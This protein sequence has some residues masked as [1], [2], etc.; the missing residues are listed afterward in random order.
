VAHEI[1]DDHFDD[2]H[3]VLRN[4]L[5]LTDAR[6]VETFIADVSHSRLIELS[7]SP[8]AGRFDVAHLRAIHRFIFQ[9]VFPWAGDFRNVMT[10]RSG[11]FGFPPPRFI[12][13][14]LETIFAALRNEAHLRNLDADQFALRAGHYFGEINAVHAFREGNGRAQREFI[15][16]L[17]LYANHPLSWAALEPA[18]IN[19]ASR[20]SFATGDSTLLSALI[21]K[22]LL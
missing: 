16:T 7:K 17:A 20:I 9:D 11:S 3:R 13:P 8:V 21:R 1:Y 19:E 15:R 4:T 10:S 12:A 18:E 14:S 5:G 22:R 6:L 2:V